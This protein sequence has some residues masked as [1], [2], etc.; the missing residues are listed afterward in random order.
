MAI[1]VTSVPDSRRFI[2]VSRLTNVFQS[3]PHSLSLATR[4]LIVRSVLGLVILTLIAAGDALVRSYKYYSHIIDARL[5]SGYLTSRPGVLQVGQ[6]LPHDKLV[7]TL[8]RAGYVESSAS[9]VWSGSFNDQPSVI[10]IRPSRANRQ[11][12]KVVKVSFSGDE[13][14]GLTGDDISLDSFTLEPE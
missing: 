8:R 3:I 11:Q 5:A 6:K 14:S 2:S 7:N 9:D 10:E 1:E 12:P 13:I 4:S